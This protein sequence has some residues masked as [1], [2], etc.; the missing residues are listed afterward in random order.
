[1]KVVVVGCLHGSLTQLYDSIPADT[2]L[3]LCCGDF[4][5]LR[6]EY[7]LSTLSCPAKHRQIGSFVGYY[8]G[9][10]TAPCLTIVVGG[11]HEASSYFLELA[12]GGWLA[13]NIYYLGVAGSVRV[14]GL[15]ISGMSGIYSEADYLRPRYERAPL[16]ASSMRSVYHYRQYDAA[17]LALVSRTS[18]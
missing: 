11:N 16:D 9:R 3:V 2:E 10:R 6:N 4:Q 13:P 14:N 15:R 18:P 12:H 8:D 17:R 1:M 5:A 7:D